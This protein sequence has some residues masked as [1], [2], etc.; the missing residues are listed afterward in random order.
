MFPVFPVF[1]SLCQFVFRELS[2]DLHMRVFMGH[3][4]NRGTS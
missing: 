2:G 1:P 4:W 3:A